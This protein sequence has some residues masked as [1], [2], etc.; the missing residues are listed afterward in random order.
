MR[1]TCKIDPPQV[2]WSEKVQLIAFVH[3][4]SGG[5][6]RQTTLGETAQTGQAIM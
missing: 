6:M 3:T 1:S 4:T 2:N 5:E